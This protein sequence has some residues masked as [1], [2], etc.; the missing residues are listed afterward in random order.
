MVRCWMNEKNNGCEH[1]ALFTR[2]S[3]LHVLIATLLT[4]SNRCYIQVADNQAREQESGFRGG[5]MPRTP[6]S[7]LEDASTHC[8]LE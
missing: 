5:I 8:P 2:L 6:F 7:E 1:S 3:F 4:F